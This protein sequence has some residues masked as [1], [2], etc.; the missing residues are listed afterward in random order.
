[1]KK[2]PKRL[3]NPL[4]LRLIPLTSL[5]AKRLRRQGQRDRLLRRR[6]DRQHLLPAIIAARDLRRRA[7]LPPALLPLPVHL[8]QG[9]VHAVAAERVPREAD[10]VADAAVRV[11]AALV[12]GARLDR[13]GVLGG[14]GRGEW[15]RPRDGGRAGFGLAG[16]GAEGGAGEGE[17]G[18]EGA[19]REAHFGF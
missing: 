1:M 16:Y 6:D 13:A 3:R 10:G 19:G 4:H 12:R 15:V 9:A 2:I 8:A 11:L 18:E 17:E 7:V 14:G 5:P